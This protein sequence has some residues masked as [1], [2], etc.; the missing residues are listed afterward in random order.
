MGKKRAVPCGT[1]EFR[2]ETSKNAE[3]DRA[4]LLHCTI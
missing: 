1:A 3:S 4:A 2:E